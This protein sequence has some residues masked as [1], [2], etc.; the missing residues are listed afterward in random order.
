[1]GWTENRRV[2]WVVAVVGGVLSVMSTTPYEAARSNLSSYFEAV[3]LNRVAE[4]LP[5]GA[6]TWG[7]R[8]GVVLMAA[9]IVIPPIA[10]R[11]RNASKDDELTSILIGHP[12]VLHF[13]PESG[14]KK[15]IT[16]L[17][18]GTIGSGKNGNEARWCVTQ[19]M[20]QIN[21]A[22]GDLQNRFSY[23]AA[24]QRLSVVEDLEAMGRKYQF[25]VK[26]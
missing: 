1:M 12:W 23:D 17:K 21:R 24:T 22:N 15:T 6:D 8:I 16:F 25:I 11:F 14:G 19:G 9:A 18:D 10:A 7:L 13:N 20:L 2:Q 4:W 5:L 26:R 3:G